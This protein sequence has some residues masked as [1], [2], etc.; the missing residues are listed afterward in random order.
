MGD[1]LGPLPSDDD[2]VGVNFVENVR[3]LLFPQRLMPR[4]LL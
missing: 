1:P 3:P 4:R 2:G